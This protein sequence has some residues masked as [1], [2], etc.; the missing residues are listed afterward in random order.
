[1][2]R[3]RRARRRTLAA[4]DARRLAH[5]V[6]EVEADLRRVALAAAAD[7]LVAL[8]VV[9][10]ADA[11]VAEDA[12]LVVDGDDGRRRVGRARVAVR[13]AGKS[14]SSRRAASRALCGRW[15][16][17]RS[18]VSTLRLRC[19]T[20]EPVFTFIPFSQG[21]MH[22]ACSVRAPSTSTT[23]MRHTP[24]GRSRGSWQRT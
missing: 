1:D 5:R 15:S 20:A 21:R 24:T 13:E 18:S 17:I 11:A 10:R 14:A 3:A 22:E 19:T 4:L 16:A 8:D 9:A 2:Q 23:H 12:S 7:D 6:V